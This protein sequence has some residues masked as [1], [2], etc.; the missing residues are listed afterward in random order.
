MLIH[1]HYQRTVPA[2]VALLILTLAGCQ[3]SVR[4]SDS[5][6]EPSRSVASD[7]QQDTTNQASTQN[8][9]ST[10]R[11]DHSQRLTAAAM[12]NG[13]AVRWDELQP[14]LAEA[15]GGMVLEELALDRM[16][17]NR[18]QREDIIITNQDI[19]QERSL[20]LRQLHDDPDKA[21][22]LLDQ[23]RARRGFG[24]KRFQLLM[25]RNAALRTLVQKNRDIEVTEHAV[26]RLFDIQHGPKRQP[27]LIVVPTLG[28]ARKAIER[29]ESG[30]RFGDVAVELS[31]DSSASRGGLLEPI[32][33]S[34]PAYPKALRE[35]LWRLEVG[36]RSDPILLDNQYAVLKLVREVPGD[37]IEL[38]SVRATLEKQVR[39]N[40]ER[41]AMDELARQLLRQAS[42]TIFNE[43]LH[44]SWNNRQQ[45]QPP[46]ADW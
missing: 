38:S 32:S 15:A 8:A 7:H 6:A 46:N 34:D 40:Q 18:L 43:S 29:L 13:Q 19:E 27:R 25:E 23:L 26:E 37:G 42:V 35:A 2:I 20:L 28:D 21:R 33:R 45:R 44:E 36:E 24:H 31:T 1:F 17:E 3:T 22:R 14:L 16:L 4:P 10:S 30:Q 39:L 41:L 5:D 11:N 9:K 12:I